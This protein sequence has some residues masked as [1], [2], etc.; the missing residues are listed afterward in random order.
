MNKIILSLAALAALSTASFAERNY[1]LR[2]LQTLNG[3]SSSGVY[4]PAMIDGAT[5]DKAAFAVPKAHNGVLSAYERALL[6]GE[7]T[8]KGNR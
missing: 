1:D 7:N 8:Q 5:Q 6:N 2:D 4:L 3:Q